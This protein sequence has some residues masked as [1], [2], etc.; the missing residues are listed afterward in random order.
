MPSNVTTQSRRTLNAF[1]WFL[2][3]SMKL[4]RNTGSQMANRDTPEDANIVNNHRYNGFPPFHPGLVDA[5]S[6][7]ALPDADVIA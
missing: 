7:F 4:L 2:F 3:L 6:L 1:S 5:Q